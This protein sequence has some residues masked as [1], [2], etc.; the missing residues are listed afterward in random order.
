MRRIPV[1]G[2]IK[3][4]IKDFLSPHGILVGESTHPL[5]WSPLQHSGWDREKKAFTKTFNMLYI[6]SLE[7][8]TLTTFYAECRVKKDV[9]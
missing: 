7:C 4:Q 6:T 3:P 9:F 8:K 1:F 5:P 2:K